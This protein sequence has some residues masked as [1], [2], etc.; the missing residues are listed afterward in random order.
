VSIRYSLAS[1]QVRNRA[2]DANDVPRARTTIPRIAALVIDD[3]DGDFHASM[4][5]G[6]TLT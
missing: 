6:C 3:V 1:L 4:S 2:R 5:T